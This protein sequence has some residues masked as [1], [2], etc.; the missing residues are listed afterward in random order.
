[1]ERAE[2]LV[3]RARL[4]QLNGFADHV[5]D[6]QP[7]LDFS[8]D[9]AC[10][11]TS[12]LPSTALDLRIAGHGVGL[13]SLDRPSD[14]Y[15]ITP[16]PG[17]VKGFVNTPMGYSHLPCGPACAHVPLGTGICPGRLFSL[18]WEAANPRALSDFAVQALTCARGGRDRRDNRTAPANQSRSRSRG[19]LLATRSC[20]RAIAQP[21]QPMNLAG[22]T[23]VEFRARH[24]HVVCQ[25]IYLLT[26][27]EGVS[28]GPRTRS[29]R[30]V[31]PSSGGRHIP[32]PC[33][34]PPQGRGNWIRKLVEARPPA[35]D[36]G[37][38]PAFR[39]AV[40][41]PWPWRSAAPV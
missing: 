27:R 12:G 5:D 21:P 41:R 9:S 31:I 3:G 14:L 20:R 36:E 11:P 32:W 33:G 15:Y 2:A 10:Q 34:Q 18:V 19:P 39:H 17:L 8:C 4:L 16:N 37:A 29:L 7:A 1:M 13:S 25:P 22:Q 26:W 35:D 40:R 30:L 38:G 23:Q 28:V 6:V 24:S